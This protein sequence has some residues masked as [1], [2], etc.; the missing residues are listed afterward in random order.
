M[1]IQLS[2]TPNTFLIFTD[3]T[4]FYITSIIDIDKSMNIYNI[5]EI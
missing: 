4:K 1:V 5:Y 2:N 3:I